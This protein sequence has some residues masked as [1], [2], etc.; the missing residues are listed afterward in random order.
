M[1]LTL[2][3][4][5]GYKTGIV[6]T[7]CRLILS[8]FI[9]SLFGLSPAYTQLC[10]GS[11]GD[12]VVNINFGTGP[13]Y[14]QPL[15]PA[16]TNYSYDPNGCPNDGLYVIANTLTSCYNGAWY[17]L[18]EDHTPGDTAGYMMV[19][20]ASNTPGDFYV[21][22]VGNLC[23]GTTYQVAAWII[24]ISKPFTCGGNSNQP[25][26]SFQIETASGAVLLKSS[27]GNIATENSA[28]WKQ[29]GAFFTMPAGTT[30]VI[31]RLTN[32]APGGCGNDLALDDI[33]FSPCG[34]QITTT[35]NGGS[36]VYNYC[37]G[38][39]PSIHFTASV[40]SGASVSYQWQSSN[41]NGTSWQDIAGATTINYSPPQT[42]I[43]GTYLYRL[44]AAQGTDISIASCR[45]ASTPLTINVFANPTTSL[46]TN[47]P[48]CEEQD[49][50]ISATNGVQYLWTGPLSF[51]S[52][53]STAILKN[54]DTINSGKYYVTV[55]SDK[56][57]TIRDSISITVFEKPVIN[58]VEPAG[59]CEGGSVMLNV[60]GY[61]FT[62]LKWSPTATLSADSISN[63]TA[64][65]TNTITYFISAANTMCTITDSVKITVFNKPVADAGND[66]I[67]FIGNSVLLTGNAGGTDVSIAWNPVNYLDQPNIATPRSSSPA[68]ITYKLTVTSNKGC[69]VAS[70]DVFVKVYAK[71]IPNAFSPNNDGIND[72]WNIPF[73]ELYPD[74]IITV[75]N[76]Y[77]QPVYTTSGNYKPWDGK[78]KGK[79]LPAATYYY[80]VVSTDNNLKYSG[81]VLIIR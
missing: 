62:R 79:P 22:Q 72:R 65:P 11:L 21:Q 40:I 43:A 12:P 46:S 57:C 1:P 45:I 80:T 34:A 20:N 31:I 73:L 61:N 49:L 76:R 24:N 52:N 36:N 74:A 48:I 78:Q 44:S 75:F 81:S 10:L 25:R 5:F 41:N 6:K 27:T 8:V 23:A 19:V 33:T 66:K 7:S 63:P 59:F 60:T 56:G 3:G 77:G 14:G 18:A 53:A 37:V 70:D 58:I 35:I 28:V 16:I 42:N 54:A 67:S 13:N 68:D 15:S 29:Y 26:I 17:P 39:S 30:S 4:I 50:S 47:A 69:G 9:L 64:S 71:T 32:D 51:T 38:Q 2:W 55:N